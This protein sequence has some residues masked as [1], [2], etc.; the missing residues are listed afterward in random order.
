MIIPG[1]CLRTP[2]WTWANKVGSLEG[3]S[4]GLRTWIC[5]NVAPASNAAW[6]LSTCS[7]GV[8]GTAGL[9]ALRGTEPVMATATTT[10]LMLRLLSCHSYASPYQQERRH[11]LDIEED[12]LPVSLK[13]DIE[14]VHLG[15]LVK[16][17]LG[18]Q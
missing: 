16:R 11:L 3:L 5:T 7:A 17:A 6:V 1:Q 4:S 8:M 15:F 9:S 12:S 18:N 10:G 13:M 2:S 14:R